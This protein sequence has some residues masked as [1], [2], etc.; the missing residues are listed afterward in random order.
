MTLTELL[1]MVNRLTL[2]EKEQLL[3]ELEQEVDAERHA[4]DTSWLSEIRHRISGY[5]DGSIPTY[6]QEEV[7]AILDADAEATLL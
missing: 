4:A 6:S 7:D 3:D 2:P 5:Y 1:P